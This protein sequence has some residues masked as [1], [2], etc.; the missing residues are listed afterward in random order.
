MVDHRQAGTGQAP[1]QL[2]CHQ[3]PLGNAAFLQ[4]KLSDS[5]PSV[6]SSNLKPFHVSPRPPRTL[7]T[8]PEAGNARQI[9]QGAA[10]R[11]TKAL[12]PRPLFHYSTACPVPW[13]ASGCS[14]RC[15]IHLQLFPS[16]VIIPKCLASL[17]PAAELGTEGTG[18]KSCRW[19]TLEK[20]LNNPKSPW[21]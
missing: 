6:A 15:F 1:L 7:V 20:I 13:A 2:C 18:W 21:P 4:S 3:C 14:Q 8:K 11:T 17:T 19:F 9:L 5:Q 16:P 12:E 10:G